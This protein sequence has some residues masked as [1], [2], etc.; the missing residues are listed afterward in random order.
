MNSIVFILGTPYCGST[1]LASVLS[2]FEKV[3]NIGELDR[4]EGLGNNENPL[5][6]NWCKVC[7][8]RAQ[9]CSI[10]DEELIASVRRSS[11]HFERYRIF[12]EV[13]GAEVLLDGSKHAYWLNTVC[14][15]D[16]VLELAR[17]IVLV[18]HPIA[19]V[20]SSHR[21]HADYKRP[22]WKWCEI[23]RD[24][25]FDLLRSCSRNGL[26]Y[27]IVNYETLCSAPERT[28]RD[29]IGF[30]GIASPEASLKNLSIHYIGGN[31]ELSAK[32]GSGEEIGVSPGVIDEN[33]EDYLAA[34]DGLLNT[35]GCFELYHNIF[36]YR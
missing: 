2:R 3:F 20:L 26:P 31:P 5:K 8:C 35:P 24:T 17:P 22:L 18:R 13:G 21:R 6:D 7:S 27:L 25:Y 12:S 28:V 29:I 14:A 4:I 30:C 33:S 11:S 15:E 9:P 1:F 36:G 19:F 16:K 23:W 34:W 10:F 32:I